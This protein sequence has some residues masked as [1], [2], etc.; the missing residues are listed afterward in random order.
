MAE[1]RFLTIGVEERL[2]ISKERS[3]ATLQGG[4]RLELETTV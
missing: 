2:Q 4:N 3:R 1:A